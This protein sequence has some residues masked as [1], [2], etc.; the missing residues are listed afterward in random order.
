MDAEFL[1]RY[2]VGR[3]SFKVKL[4]IRVVTR[5]TE[6]L[7][8]HTFGMYFI[9]CYKKVTKYGSTRMLQLQGFSFQDVYHIV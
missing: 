7:N 3:T 6:A 1:F 2:T 9:P 4:S 8:L 5:P